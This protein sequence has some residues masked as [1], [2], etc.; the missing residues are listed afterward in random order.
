MLEQAIASMSVW[1]SHY[2]IFGAFKTEEQARP[3]DH[4]MV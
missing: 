1:E 2:S 3:L 4:D